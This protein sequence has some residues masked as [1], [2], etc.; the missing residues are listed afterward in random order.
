MKL[1]K[2]KKVQKKPK[3]IKVVKTSSIITP[4][5]SGEWKN[6]FPYKPEMQDY[7]IITTLSDLK[8][9]CQEMMKIPAFAYDTETNTLEVLGE[10]KNFKCVGI[11]ISWGE[12]NNY[13]IPVGHVRE[14]DINYQLTID[15]RVY[16]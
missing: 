2:L 10:N 13:Y 11:S 4:N 6:N 15:V 8:S 7:E 14:E 5:Y 1:L 9:L 3:L 16:F 12:D